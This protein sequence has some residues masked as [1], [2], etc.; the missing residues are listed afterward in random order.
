MVAYSVDRALRYR[1]TSGSIDCSID[2][3]KLHSGGIT[4]MKLPK[5]FDFKPGQFAQVQIPGIDSSYHPFT[6]ASA[7][8]DEYIKFYIRA[9]GT[10][11]NALRDLVQE[12]LDSGTDCDPIT[13]RYRG[14]Y[15]APAQHVSSYR[16]VVLVA[17]GVGST[18][19]CSIA[20]SCDNKLKD[21]KDVLPSDRNTM[22][23]AEIDRIFSSA[24]PLQGIQHGDL[25]SCRAALRF[26]TGIGFATGAMT[27]ESDCRH[28]GGSPHQ[29][30]GF[31][32][33]DDEEVSAAVEVY[34]EKALGEKLH[35]SVSPQA[36]S[37]KIAG[38]PA[39]G[40]APTRKSKVRSSVSRFLLTLHSVRFSLFLL[41]GL[42]TRITLVLYAAVLGGL[43]IGLSSTRLCVWHLVIMF[44]FKISSARAHKIQDM[45]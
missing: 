41:W 21:S 9:A 18:P 39:G 28:A 15:G 45:S 14:P 33:E 38:T 42:L 8:H 35:T 6:I 32:Q 24:T 10:W 36:K 13:V 44:Q 20:R 11:T 23:E 1:R 19:F 40:A 12:K 3:F 43:N 25:Q 22:V 27:N 17:G 7:Q 26:S 34:T 31:L 2:C 29:K 37:G 5:L 30:R 4:G 16:N